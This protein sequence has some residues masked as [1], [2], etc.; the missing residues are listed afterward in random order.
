MGECWEN[1]RD[2]CKT[3]G[4]ANFKHPE[5]QVNTKYLELVLLCMGL[6]MSMLEMKLNDI[7]FLHEDYK[8]LLNHDKRGHRKE[9]GK[10]ELDEGEKRL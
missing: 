8:L 6:S 1:T 2:A 4:A 3:R 7:N 10:I 5:F 9:R